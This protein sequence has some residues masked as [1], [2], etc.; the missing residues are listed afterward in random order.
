MN[1]LLPVSSLMVVIC[2]IAK[3]SVFLLFLCL[4]QVTHFVPTVLQSSSGHLHSDRHGVLYTY[5]VAGEAAQ[6]DAKAG[7]PDP[8]R[9][10]ALSAYK[11]ARALC[12]IAVHPWNS[13]PKRVAPVERP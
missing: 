9:P 1:Y 2:Q 12:N 4:S 8:T 13:G 11:P 5:P 10:A 3:T 7:R 6:D